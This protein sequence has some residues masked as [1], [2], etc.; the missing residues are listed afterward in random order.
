MK[1]GLLTIFCCFIFSIGGTAQELT[2][3]LAWA[4]KYGQTEYLDKWIPDDQIEACLGTSKSKKYKFLAMS[5]KLNSMTS[6]KY[7]VERG[8][9]IEG[10]CAEKS[11]LMYAAK[12]GKPD[13]IDYLVSLGADPNR[14]IQR[15][16]A[17]YY[18]RKFGRA[19]AAKRLKSYQLN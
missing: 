10:N 5:V 12:Y 17:L 9:D 13:M 16:T 2:K 3:E 14:I 8:A 11:P 1:A 18:A 7:F 6:L 19:E 4:I 15:K